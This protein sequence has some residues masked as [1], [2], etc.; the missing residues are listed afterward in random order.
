MTISYLRRTDLLRTALLLCA[1]F[2]GCLQQMHAQPDAYGLSATGSS[3]KWLT[4]S[5]STGLGALQNLPVAAGTTRYNG[6]LAQRSQ[7]VRRDHLGNI[8]FFVVDGRVYDGQGYLIADSRGTGCQQCVDPGIVDFIS[9]P[10]PGS[11]TR[12][13]LFSASGQTLSSPARIQWS[14]L[15]LEANNPYHAGRKGALLQHWVQPFTT[16]FPSWAPLAETGTGIHTS[17]YV[18]ALPVDAEAKGTSPIIRVVRSGTGANAH[19]WLFLLLK[20]RIYPYKVSSTEIAAVNPVAGYPYVELYYGA[21]VQPKEFVRDADVFRNGNEISVAMVDG[22][23]FTPYPQPGSTNGNL[24]VAKFNNTSGALIGGTTSVYQLL[25]SSNMGMDTPG[26]STGVGSLTGCVFGTNANTLWLT[27]QFKISGSWVPRI[28]TF[29]LTTAT[30]TDRTSLVPSAANYVH[31]RI[32]RNRAPNGGSEAIYFPTATGV[33]VLTGIE[34]PGTATFSATGIAAP[35]PLL[36]IPA[37]G[38]FMPR[39]LNE[40]VKGEDF[41]THFTSEDCC[42]S[43]QNYGAVYGHTVSTS[44]TFAAPWQPGSHPFGTSSTIV[45]AQDLVVPAGQRLYLKD[46]TIRFAA[47]AKLVIQQGGY[48]HT[49]N[50]RLTAYDCINARWPGVRIY[51]TYTMP[52]TTDIAPLNQGRME[53]TSASVIEY[54]QVGVQLGTDVTVPFYV[55]AGGGILNADNSSFLNCKE[56]VRIHPYQNFQ[57]GNPSILWAN[58]TSFRSVTFTVNASYPGTYDFQHHVYMNLVSGIVFTASNF[59]NERSDASFSSTG[60]LQLGHGIRSLDAE[61]KVLSRCSVAPPYGQPCAPANVIRSTF[62]GLDHGIH[63]LVGTTTRAFEVDRAAFT[64]NICGVYT[65]GTVGYKVT[66]NN[67]TLGNRNVALNNPIESPSWALHHRG[68]FSSSSYGFIVEDNTFQRQGTRP[69][70]GIV[71]GYSRDHNDIVFR[72]TASGMDAAFVGEGT[73]CDI[74]QKPL[75]GLQFR[76]NQNNGNGYNIWNRVLTALGNDLAQN[77]TIRTVQGQLDF[78]AGNTFD[79]VAGGILESDLHYNSNLNVTNYIGHAP[80]SVYDPLDIDATYFP[81]TIVPTAPSDVCSLKL[82]PIMLQ[83][84]DAMMGSGYH[85][86]LEQERET[87]TTLRYVYDNLID[88]GSTDAMLQEI[89][90]TWPAEVWELR[91]SLMAKAPYLSTDVLIEAVNK[92][93]LPQA[94]VLEVCL[95]NPEA[96]QTDGFLKWLEGTNTLPSYMLGL[97]EESW[98]TKTFRFALENELAGHY[99]KM[100]QAVNTLLQVY[101]ADTLVEHVDSLRYAWQELRSPA[102]RYAEAMALLQLNNFAGAAT[103]IEGMRDEHRLKEEQETE[104]GRMLTFITFQQGVKAAGRSMAELTE[105]EVDQLEHSVA[106]SNDRPGTWARNI[107][108]FHYQRCV[109]PPSGWDTS[110]PKSNHPQ[111]PPVEEERKTDLQVYPNPAAT[112][113]T[114]AYEL[115]EQPSNAWITILDAAG[116]KVTQLDVT[117][118]KGHVAWDPRGLTSG[119]YIVELRNNTRLLNSTQLLVP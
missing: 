25:S 52:Q 75:V 2:L 81:K 65:T 70:E 119:T 19:Q 95:A 109:A 111:P 15:D 84:P 107:L 12:F 46:L 29:D 73:C 8:L 100:A 54:A 104:L 50:T 74:N 103:L 39:F 90:E 83:G 47:N 85:T 55:L 48:V 71:I 4:V 66:N 3:Y 92:N 44:N 28:G 67:F 91:A 10:V 31:S 114:F 105:A 106:L 99:A 40:G 22:Q 98:Q 77:Q 87:A 24:T 23:A 59:K 88:G 20:N 82:P 58:R 93:I 11:C 57:S 118:Q 53:M 7:M 37:T 38:Y 41:L 101:H 21:Q 62:I 80:S 96:T 42:I 43:R 56:S 72:N 6:Q 17:S 112:W 115:D 79:R 5:Q 35:A 18:A 117:T 16:L 9:T 64:N 51:G 14:V 1:C 69:T 86:S 63:A 26:P 36:S 110:N 94:V 76:C 34:T 102:A 27:G 108:C 30:F 60:S 97:I 13:F 61:Y 33:G 45:F 78:P 32:Y 89:S 116:R 49:R 113:V 68:L